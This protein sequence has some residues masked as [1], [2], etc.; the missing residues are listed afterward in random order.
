M[1][2]TNTSR[3]RQERR[4]RSWS[5][6]ALTMRTGIDP[7]S[8]SL[9]E[10]GLVVAHPGWRRRIADALGMKEEDLFDGRSVRPAEAA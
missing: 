5:L 10:R 9:L 8:L 6:M 2:D 3:L 7:G 1:K 4:R